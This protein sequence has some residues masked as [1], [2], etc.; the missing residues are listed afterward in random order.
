M[1]AYSGG[2]LLFFCQQQMPGTG[3]LTGH[4]LKHSTAAFSASGH[5]IERGGEEKRER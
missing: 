2:W 4:T 3:V 5:Q 1:D